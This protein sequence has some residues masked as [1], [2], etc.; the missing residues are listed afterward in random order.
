MCFY[1]FV[2]R[3]ARNEQGLR[4]EENTWIGHYNCGGYAL[5][6]FSWYCPC[7]DK[8]NDGNYF[9][10][11]NEEEL[12]LITQKCIK[13]MLKDFSG[14][15]VIGNLKELEKNE[16]AI[17][18][19]IGG[20]YDDFHYCVRKTNGHWYQKCGACPIEKVSKNYVFNEIWQDPFR[21]NRYI[22]RVVLLAK[23]F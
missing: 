18:F 17:A 6:T 16:Y 9:I 7:E 15:R 22:G 3:D 19:R 8:E 13:K 10:A 2:K 12:E 1:T 11:N 4:N 23:T 14:L 20:E 21:I 5:R